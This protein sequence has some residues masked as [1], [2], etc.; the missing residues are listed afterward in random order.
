MVFAQLKF[1]TFRFCNTGTL[2]ERLYPSR[3]KLRNRVFR[4]VK[5]GYYMTSQGLAYLNYQEGN[6]HNLATEA[7]AVNELAETSRHNR[8][9]EYETNRHDLATEHET[10]KHNRYEEK[11]N[12]MNAKTNQ[13]NLKVRKKELKETTRHD[14]ATERLTDRDRQ[15][16]TRHN[17]ASEAIQDRYNNGML[18]LGDAKIATTKYGIQVGAQTAGADRASRE[19]IARHNRRQVAQTEKYKTDTQYLTDSQKIAQQ[20]YGTDVKGKTDRD[21]TTLDTMAKVELGKL[22]MGTD[23]YNNK[24]RNYTNLFGSLAGLIG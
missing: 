3:T 17:K 10:S 24:T 18:R 5:G 11:T 16:K 7:Q 4:E 15:E 23:I 21:R 20:R 1:K 14:K 12:R 19:R 13:G 2:P 9:Y 6:R 22:R 8:A